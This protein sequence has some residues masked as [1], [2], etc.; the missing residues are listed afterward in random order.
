MTGAV[1]LRGSVAPSADRNN[2][3]GERRN[4]PFLLGARPTATPLNL[5]V[6]CIA[7]AGM[8]VPLNASWSVNVCNASGHPQ[9]NQHDAYSLNSI[10]AIT[11]KSLI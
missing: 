3:R 10:T 8:A 11:N 2:V 1:R 5:P 9:K 4:D 7:G 6:E